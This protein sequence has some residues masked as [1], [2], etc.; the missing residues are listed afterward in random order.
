MDYR[1]WQ[2][3]I[4]SVEIYEMRL[5]RDRCKGKCK[6]RGRVPPGCLLAV[7]SQFSVSMLEVIIV[8]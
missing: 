1:V 2:I 3:L 7:V 6:G 8:K 4:G 5:R